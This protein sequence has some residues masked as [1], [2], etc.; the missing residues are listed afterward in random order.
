MNIFQKISKRIK[1]GTLSEAIRDRLAVMGFE[2]FAFYWIRE[3]LENSPVVELRDDVNKYEFGLFG[4]EEMKII[5]KLAD[6]PKNGRFSGEKALCEKLDR[7]WKCYGAKV[8]GEIAAFSWFDPKTCH[9]WLN[10]M[11]LKDNEAYLFDMFTYEKFRG[12]NLAP[13]LR[14]KSFE[15]LR[16]HNKDTFYS[17]TMFHNKPSLRFKEKL[18]AKKIYLKARFRLFKK[19]EWD[20]I[21]WRY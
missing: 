3:D 10:K 16:K 8:D 17:V 12:K 2:I 11:D 7:G 9:H 20:S 13:Y 1:D 14:H 6:D 21:L 19:L 4:P 18:N 5:G 15:E